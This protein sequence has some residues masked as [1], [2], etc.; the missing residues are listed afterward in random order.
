MPKFSV[1]IA[2]AGLGGLAAA[3][4]TARKGRST[5]LLEP[6]DK[7]GGVH[8][9]RER[10]G[11]RFT[12]APVLAFGFERGGVLSELNSLLGIACSASVLS[13]CYQVVLPDRRV[14]IYLDAGE[15]LEELRREFPREIDGITKLFR[16]VKKLA[17][18]LSTSR[19]AA[20]F[21]RSRNAGGLLRR[22]RFTREF[23]VYLDI[24]SRAFFRRPI[25]ELPLTS[26]ILLLDNAPLAVQGGFSAYEGQLLEAFLRHGGE[27]RLGVSWPTLDGTVK[28]TVLLQTREGVVEAE[29][30]MFN[31][32]QGS[33]PATL[34]TGLDAA[35]VPVGMARE[36]ICLQDYGRPEDLFTLSVSGQ[37][38][39]A[40]APKGMRAL[41]A[42]FRAVP[43]ETA[44]QQ[45]LIDRISAVIPYLRHHMK[46]ADIAQ[47]PDRS[48]AFP[49]DI[50]FRTLRAGGRDLILSR[51]GSLY[52]IPDGTGSP[53]D[54]V[55]AATDFTGRMA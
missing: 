8:V 25:A 13:P 44:E 49:Q 2:G 6:S 51:A 14:S 39:E 36:V 43:R 23:S 54:A 48:Y 18:R 29:A 4:M 26:L 7:V 31:T 5:V 30:A 42:T 15:T 41:S 21:Y 34:F 53:Q 1:T 3:A 20:F 12:N 22:Y 55:L 46:F 33:V 37:D 11:F 40:A 28:R 45:P 47:E 17:M 24:Q 19:S 9:L 50:R 16:D 27:A 38:D 32:L 35:V 10:D 52:L